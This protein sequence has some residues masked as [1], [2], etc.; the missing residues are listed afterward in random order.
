MVTPMDEQGGVNYEKAAEIARRFVEE[1][2]TA[3]VVSGTTGESPTLSAAEKEK[4]FIAIKKAVDVPVIAGAG[5][6]STAASI[7]NARRAL[8]CGVDGLLA[9][10]PYYNKPNQDSIY[11]H[12]AAFAQATPLPVMLYNVPGRTGTNMTA[13]TSIALSQIPNITALKEASGDL[14]QLAKV[15]RDANA[16]F[17]VYTG[18]DAQILPTLAVGRYGVVSVASQVVGREIQRMIESH[19]AGR[20]AEAAELHLKLVGIVE[21]L[22]MTANPIPIKAAL[23]LMGLEVG[24]TRLPLAPPAPAVVRALREELTALNLIS[25]G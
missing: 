1:G 2:T 8:D 9:V 22:F 11:A 18:E 25:G 3:L 14:V 16:D 17:A 24:C 13:E 19:L 20:A 23:N 12:F 5:T 21:K 7:E 15:V 10:V 4:L 6:N